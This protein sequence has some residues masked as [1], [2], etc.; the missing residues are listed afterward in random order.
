MS[1]QEKS[2]LIAM[3]L[4]NKKWN[5]AIGDGSDFR[6]RCI[7]AR[8]QA[9]LK[10]E[11]TTARQKLKL[12]AS[13]PIVFCYEA[14]RDGFWIKRM[15]EKN[16][17]ACHIMDPASIEISRKAR[18][19]KTDRLD[20]KKLLCLLI[21]KVLHHE[22]RAFAE[23]R[24]PTEE[25]EAAKRLHRE[26]QRLVKEQSGHISRIKALYNL[27]GVIAGPKG[28]VEEIRD[29][30]GRP[31]P[32]PLVSEIAR[33]QQRLG[34][35]EEQIKRLEGQQKTALENPTSPAEKKAE[36]LMK[37]KAIGPQGSWV[38]CH[39]CFGWR[40]F[41]NRKKLGGFSGLT[42]T[43]FSSGE[44]NREQGISKA[45][46]HRVRAVMIELA[47]SWVRWQPHSPITHWFIDRY[48]RGGTSRSKRKG[49]VAV[50]R[51]LLVALW[52]Y[53]EQDIMPEGAILKA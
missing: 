14:G 31:L 40:T 9:Q 5:L 6:E 28:K 44:I 50:A 4:G 17:W 24:M 36:K 16:G 53:V 51:K 12:K 29:W 34:L 19:R 48:V 15:L 25:Q 13:S 45:G 41:E 33:E 39:E 22:E 43:P 47:W 38:L 23:V 10:H 27:H 8:N 30:N 20:A 3:D 32:A 42:G 21:R 7:E 18:Q 52:K 1:L 26:R 46:S 11:V 35:I 37:L 49:I 2:L